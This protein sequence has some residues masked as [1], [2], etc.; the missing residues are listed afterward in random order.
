MIILTETTDTIKAVLAA[1]KTTNDMPCVVGYRDI[2]TDFVP[3]K[4]VAS[5]NGT[6]PVTIQAAP[7]SSHQLLVDLISIHNA[8]T[9]AHSVTVNLDDN[10]TSCPLWRG[11]LQSGESVKYQHGKSWR[12]LDSKGDA[13]DVTVAEVSTPPATTTDLQRFTSDGT[14]TKPTSFTPKLSVVALVG[15]GGGGGGGHSSAS[16]VQPGCGGGGGAYNLKLFLTSDLGSTEDAV[17]GAGG[18]GGALDTSGT[19]GGNSSFGTTTPILLAGG[20]GSGYKSEGASTTNPGNGGGGGGT[21]GVGTNGGASTSVGTGGPPGVYISLETNGGL[22][23][24]GV[25]SD[26]YVR[27]AEYGGGGGGGHSS[28]S[29]YTQM[30]G[31]SLFGAGGGG[32]GTGHCITD[33]VTPAKWGGR[34]GMTHMANYGHEEYV[35]CIRHRPEHHTGGAAGSSG[36]TATAGGDGAAG[37]SIRC[38][39][40]GGGGGT[41]GSGAA[42][43]GG[44]GG[45]PGGGGGGGGSADTGGVGGD[46]ARGE[47]RV[48]TW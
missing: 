41:P 32:G 28:D 25:A 34:S 33:V 46:G 38:G 2:L 8:D 24:T 35:D 26:S 10:G 14:W 19:A 13:I 12:K 21:G 11:T 27:H 15:G 17:V 6:A 36:Q 42:G 30:G 16:T 39:H 7:A 45:I 43:K 1:A 29:M 22:G 9:V 4:S 40:G 5:T 44:N 3:H 23:G 37:N 31:S 18:G 47:V 48:Y 20:G